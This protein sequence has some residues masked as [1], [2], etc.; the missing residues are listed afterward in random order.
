MRPHLP[1]DAGRANAFQE[2]WAKALGVE[3]AVTNY[4]GMA[5]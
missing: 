4:A 3:A 5:F 1:F 2:E